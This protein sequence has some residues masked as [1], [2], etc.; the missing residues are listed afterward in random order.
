MVAPT[1]SKY[2]CTSSITA[3]GASIGNNIAI[4]AKLE[5]I[6]VRKLT[7]AITTK[8]MINIENPLR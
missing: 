3:V 5:V 1:M 8:R 7:T 6:S 2:G 4:V